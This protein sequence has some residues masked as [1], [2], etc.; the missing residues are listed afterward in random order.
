MRAHHP[1]DQSASVQHRLSRKNRSRPALPLLYGSKR[2][3]LFTLS[4]DE[5]AIE[6]T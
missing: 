5:S 2:A 4:R 3:V 6:S 1:V